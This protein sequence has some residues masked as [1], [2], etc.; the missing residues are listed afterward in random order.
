M[1]TFFTAAAALA[2]A[3]AAELNQGYGPYYNYAPYTDDYINNPFAGKY[4]NYGGRY[5]NDNYGRVREEY[6]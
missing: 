6:V 3:K 4:S 2:T 5:N 1:K